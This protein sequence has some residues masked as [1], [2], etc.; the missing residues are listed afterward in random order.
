M[1]EWGYV[2]LYGLLTIEVVLLMLTLGN[3]LR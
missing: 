3:L 1:K 2:F